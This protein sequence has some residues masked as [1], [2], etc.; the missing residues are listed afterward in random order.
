M[1]S[2]TVTSMATDMGA[3]IH[4]DMSTQWADLVV[5][6]GQYQH[7]KDNKTRHHC[8]FPHSNF[9]SYFYCLLFFLLF[10]AFQLFLV[11]FCIDYF[12][13]YFQKVFLSGYKK[14]MTDF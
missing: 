8:H 7:R 4:I 2:D 13:V 1:A 6:V 12:I 14:E 9:F 11:L 3:D 10:I 5:D